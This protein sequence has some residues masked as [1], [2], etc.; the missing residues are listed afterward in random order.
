MR[1]FVFFF[2]ITTVYLFA[3]CDAM[4]GKGDQDTLLVKLINDG[5]AYLSPLRPQEINNRND[6]LK[7]ILA[8]GANVDARNEYGQTALSVFA[9]S[10]IKPLVETLLAHNAN[11]NLQDKVGT[12][13]TH[14]TCMITCRNDEFNQWYKEIIKLL[15]EAK[16]DPNIK[17]LFGKAPLAMINEESVLNYLSAEEKKEITQMLQKYGAK[18]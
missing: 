3:K 14:A 12:P 8:N 10:G 2:L 7:I 4:N 18:E 6:M 9:T 15:L 11:P 1:K 17:N 5:P 16:A 13:L